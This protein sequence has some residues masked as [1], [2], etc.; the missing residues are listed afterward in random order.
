M[1]RSD[2]H[3]LVEELVPAPEPEEVFLRLCALPHCLF[4]DSAARDPMLGRYSFVTADPFDYL[5]L[6]PRPT[7]GVSREL[8]AT[9]LRS[10]LAELPVREREVLVLRYGLDGGRVHTLEELGKRFNVTRERIRQIEIRAIRK[11]Q[12]P[13][14]AQAL[15]GFLEIFP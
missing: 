5:E 9:L 2:F 7:D 3:P 4:L 15:E 11:L 13:P 10:L 12:T 8:L 14:R 6:S 1:S